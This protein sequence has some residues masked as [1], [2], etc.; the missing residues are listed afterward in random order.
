[1]TVLII[2]AS[3]GLGRALAE[4]AARRSHDVLLVASDERDL[5]AICRDLVLSRQIRAEYAACDLGHSE[6]SR[7]V[8]SAAASQFGPIDV[9]LLPAG[10]A[11]DDDNG[12][13]P[14]EASQTIVNIN[15]FTQTCV[16]AALW[17]ALELRPSACIVG[18]GSIAAIRGRRRNVL[19]AA[20]KRGLASF[21]ESLM[22]KAADTSIRVHFYHVGYLNTTQTAGK[23]L[24]VPK[25][26]P[27]AF[28]RVVFDRM[29]AAFHRPA[30][31]PAY[32]R[33]LALLIRW[34]PW[35]LYRK[36]DV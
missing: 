24:P 36:I 34:M 22:H 29:P 14:H 21:F 15:L 20:A 30:Y 31:Y 1:V 17:P 5:E 12:L 8:I 18:F 6:E 13:L 27:R 11:R 3:A 25:A 28:A 9:V 4:E 7:Q 10:F 23:D 2:G 19:Y 16:L 35:P 26:S 32:W 33:W